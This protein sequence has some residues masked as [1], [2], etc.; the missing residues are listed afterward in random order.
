MKSQINASM[1]LEKW[2][3]TRNIIRTENET[4]IGFEINKKNE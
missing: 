3:T 1:H 2:R 4:I